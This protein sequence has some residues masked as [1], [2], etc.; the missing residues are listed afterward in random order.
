MPRFRMVW[1]RCGFLLQFGEYFQFL[2]KFGIFGIFW[3]F[4][5]RSWL[6]LNVSE[7]YL[8]LIV[9]DIWDTNFFVLPFWVALLVV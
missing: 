3:L 7:I 8:C 2:W 1:A 9:C 4:F 6:R 5:L